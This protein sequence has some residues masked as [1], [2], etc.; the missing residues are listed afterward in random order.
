MVN[1]DYD[2]FDETLAKDFKLKP[3]ETE[4]IQLED[5]M[6]RIVGELNN[7]VANEEA[8][9][10]TNGINFTFSISLNSFLRIDLD[11]YY[12]FRCDLKFV[13]CR[14]KSRTGFVHA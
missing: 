3:I 4:F 11:P 10:S 5:V 2:L 12:H 1:H 6:H 9:R 8:H 14:V 13:P 7:L